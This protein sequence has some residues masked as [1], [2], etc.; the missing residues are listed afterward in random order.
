[1]SYIYF[2]K[3]YFIMYCLILFGYYLIPAGLTYILFNVIKKGKWESKRIQD[4]RPKKKS[5]IHEIKSSLVA[6][7]FFALYTTILCYFIAIGKTKVYTNFFDHSTLYFIFSILIFI[8]VQDAYFY[9]T[10]RFMHLKRIFQYVHKSH[11][12]SNPPTPFATLIFG[13]W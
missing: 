3:Q 6:I 8:I 2:I 10:H 9:L 12:L 11:H 5:I 7:V 4:R 1:M 13:T